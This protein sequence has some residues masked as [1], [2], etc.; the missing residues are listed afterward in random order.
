MHLVSKDNY[1]KYL[2]TQR[3]QDFCLNTL[4]VCIR[5]N[6]QFCCYCYSV[7]HRLYCEVNLRDDLDNHQDQVVGVVLCDL[8]HQNQPV[9]EK[10]GVFPQKFHQ[11]ERFFDDLKSPCDLFEKVKISSFSPAAWSITYGY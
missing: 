2:A 11:L 5:V 3:H 7:F 10:D 9:L 1:K 4:S 6:Y 8:H